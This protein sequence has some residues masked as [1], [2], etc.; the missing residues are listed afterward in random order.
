[1]TSY[2]QIQEWVRQRYGFVPQTCWIA[3]MKELHGLPLRDAPNRRGERVK[4]CPPER[5]GPIEEAFRHFGMVSRA[6]S[7]E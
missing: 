5:R 2:R 1:M 3:H 7:P 6:A 4:P